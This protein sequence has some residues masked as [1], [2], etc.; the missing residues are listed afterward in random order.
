VTTY[1]ASCDHSPPVNL[2]HSAV[3]LFQSIIA[4]L[5]PILWDQPIFR[6]LIST[7]TYPYLKPDTIKVLRRALINGIIL[8]P[9]DVALRQ[10]LLGELPDCK[11]Y[12]K[13]Y[14][15][16]Y[17][18]FIFI[19]RYIKKISYLD[20]MILALSAPLGMQGQPVPL[21]STISV[22]IMPLTQL[23]EDCA[24]SSTTIKKMLHSSLESIINRALELLSYVIRCQVICEVLLGFL[25]SAF[26]VLQQQ[27]GPEFMQNA[28]QGMLQLYT[29]FVQ[30][31]I[32]LQK[33]RY[34]I[35]M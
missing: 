4:I 33:Q 6:N 31:I 32:T 20:T 22:T 10:R 25:H 5:K 21:E 23:L 7:G 34:L 17:T 29:R 27:L 19:K 14:N 35:K 1:T 8:P 13:L 2:V 18:A 3:H 16:K 26:S 28:V 11:N 9:G 12:I 24:S 30:D 15:Y